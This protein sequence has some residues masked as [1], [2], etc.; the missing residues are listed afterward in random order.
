MNV[1]RI[2]LTN[3]IVKITNA[4]WRKSV[5]D[6]IKMNLRAKEQPNRNH[7]DQNSLERGK[8]IIVEDNNNFVI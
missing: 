3:C 7:G 1:V 4:S 8:Q 5:N 6:N 2:F